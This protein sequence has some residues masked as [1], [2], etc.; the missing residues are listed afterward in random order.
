MTSGMSLLAGRSS[1]APRAAGC[2][3]APCAAR[4][5]VGR[6]RASCPARSSRTRWP[7]RG[8]LQPRGHGRRAH[9]PR[10]ER[11]RGIGSGRGRRPL[12]RRPR[13]RERR[14]AARSRSRSS[15]R[16]S[17]WT[18][19]RSAARRACSTL[20]ARAEA[21]GGYV[22]IDMEQTAYTDATLRLCRRAREQARAASACACSRTCVA[23]PPTSRRCGRRARACGSSRGPT[24]SPRI[25]PSRARRTWTRATSPWRG[26]CSTRRRAARAGRTVF[27]THDRRL[28]EAIVA[29]GAAAGLPKS[30]CEFH[31]L[32]G[33]Q[34]AEQERLRARGLAGAGADQLRRLLVPLVHA[35]PGGAAGQRALRRPQRPG[36]VGRGRVDPRS[37]SG[38]ACR[39]AG[40]SDAEVRKDP[41]GAQAHRRGV[42]DV[43]RRAPLAAGRHRRRG[44]GAAGGTLRRRARGTGG[45]SRRHPHRGRGGDPRRDVGPRRP[46]PLRGRSCR[47]AVPRPARPRRAVPRADPQPPRPARRALLAAGG[48][49]AQPDRRGRAHPPPLDPRSPHPAVHGALLPRAAPGRARARARDGRPPLHRHGGGGRLRPLPGGGGRCAPA[50]RA[51]PSW[52]RSS[53]ARRARATS[54]RG[55][56]TSA[57]ASS[58]TARPRATPSGWPSGC[59]SV[60]RR[61]SFKGASALPGGR[62]TI[63]LGTAT[64]PMDGARVD[65]LFDA[66]EASLH[67][68]RLDRERAR[69]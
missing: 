49:G 42:R 69:A 58:S 65:A 60:R 23:P 45:R 9:P 47:H 25:A 5:S 36:E 3:N 51:W 31:L 16:S 4:S 33:I 28:I 50:T 62:L 8:G 44:R 41:G 12:P 63:S 66:A 14:A 13:P 2:G 11:G 34:R 52:P 27:G 22:W 57:S 1:P 43:P 68:D 39:G 56:P 17:A 55:W 54:S 21:T 18:R 67:R 15:R 24:T 6:C 53:T 37:R 20:A 64:C 59:A 32:Y 48:L 19:T 10:R 38:V 46:R 40:R 7:P 29:H 35:P 61:P 30:A 26:A